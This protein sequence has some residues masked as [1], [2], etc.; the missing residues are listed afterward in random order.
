MEHRNLYQEWNDALKAPAFDAEQLT[1][2]H[3]LYQERLRLDAAWNVVWKEAEAAYRAEVRAV[4][5]RVTAELTP[6]PKAQLVARFVQ[7]N[8]FEPDGRTW[9]KERLIDAEIDNAL[10]R[11]PDT[12]TRAKA[13]WAERHGGSEG[14][15]SGAKD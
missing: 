5:E 11:V 2:I 10:W 1:E 13:L 7:R 9:T 12:N 15:Q 4:R 14:E 6:L 8:G 3:R